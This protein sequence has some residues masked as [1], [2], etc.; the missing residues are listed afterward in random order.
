MTPSHPIGLRRGNI[1]L[2]VLHL[3]VCL[4]D[5]LTDMWSGV[6]LFSAQASHLKGPPCPSCY[7]A[8]Q[9]LMSSID[10]IMFIFIE[11]LRR[12][13]GFTWF[14]SILFNTLKFLILFHDIVVESDYLIVVGGIGSKLQLHLKDRNDGLPRIGNMVSRVAI[15]N[16][17]GDGS[18]RMSSCKT[19]IFNILPIKISTSLKQVQAYIHNGIGHRPLVVAPS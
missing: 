9:S 2:L 13:P 8:L 4:S 7:L 6:D 15:S 12:E 1:D 3:Q 10:F 11:I 14:S 16:G 18:T 17:E 19:E 5:I